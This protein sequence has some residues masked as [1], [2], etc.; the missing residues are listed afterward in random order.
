MATDK[1]TSEVRLELTYD[2]GTGRFKPYFDG[3]LTGQAIASNCQICGRTW[4]PPKAVCPDDQ[5]ETGW[6]CISGSGVV[7]G[8]TTMRSKLPFTLAADVYRFVLV[9]M[10]GTENAVFG[11]MRNAAADVAV[12]T[13]VDLVAPVDAPAHPAQAVQFVVKGD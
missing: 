12:G 13:S 2:H 8:A 4:F 10:D 11:R 9:K 7:L 5:A 6:S 3:L 1:A